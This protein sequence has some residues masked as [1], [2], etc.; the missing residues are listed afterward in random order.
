MNLKF[1]TWFK[2][3]SAPTLTVNLF[4]AAWPEK[5]RR[6]LERLANTPPG[7]PLLT[8]VLGLL[9]QAVL[10][11]VQ[12]C[13]DPKVDAAEARAIVNSIGLLIGLR[14]DIEQK[15]KAELTRKAQRDAGQPG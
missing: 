6:L 2:A 15:W 5:K 3:P 7:D 9:E 13:E 4:D 10:A 1:W 12:R 11:Q 8:G 14:L